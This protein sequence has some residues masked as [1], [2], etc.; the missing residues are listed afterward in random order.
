MSDAVVKQITGALRAEIDGGPL[1][2][3]S[4]R[5]RDGDLWFV[6]RFASVTASKPD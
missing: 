3:F 1:T 6:E 4:P 5:E 2:G